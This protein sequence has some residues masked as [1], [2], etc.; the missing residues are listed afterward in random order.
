MGKLRV[1]RQEGERG[2]A[3]AE[4]AALLKQHQ[5][6]IATAWAEMVRA[7]PGSSYADL[8]A[9]EVHSLTLRGVGA[10][11]ESLESGSRASLEGYLVDICPATSEAIPDA[12]TATEALLLCKD[13]ALPVI[14]EAWGSDSGKTWALVSPAL[15]GRP[16]HQRVGGGDG[17]AIGRREGAGGHA[18][19]HGAREGH[20][21]ESPLDR[22][23]GPDHGSPAR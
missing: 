11:V 23:T 7:L 20:H 13:V 3:S 1:G 15:D 4:L 21:Q 9:E 10:M 22:R 6:E 19:G 8:S 18:V 12:C 16:P 2:K 17:A 14:R 5:E